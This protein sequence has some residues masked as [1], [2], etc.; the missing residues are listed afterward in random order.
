MC[1]TLGG[2]GRGRAD[3]PPPPGYR[4]QEVTRFGKGDKEQ[5]ARTSRQRAH[6]NWVDAQLEVA[7]RWRDIRHKAEVRAFYANK[8]RNPPKKKE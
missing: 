6:K 7:Q 1:G 8:R 3:P 2:W 5:K 4:W